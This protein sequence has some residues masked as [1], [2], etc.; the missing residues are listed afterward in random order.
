MFI[1]S[2][3]SRI[4]K[5]RRFDFASRKIVLHKNVLQLYINQVSVNFSFFIIFKDLL[6]HQLLPVRKGGKQT[7]RKL[8]C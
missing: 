2:Q 6:S 4:A 7:E 5:E 3:H 1:F 8:A